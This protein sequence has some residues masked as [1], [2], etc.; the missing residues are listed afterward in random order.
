M[1]IDRDKLRTHSVP[2]DDYLA[3]Q[4]GA[5]AEFRAMWERTAFAR[6]LGVEVIRARTTLNLDQTA[7]AERLGVS[8]AVVEALEDGEEDPGLE[9]LTLLAE[10]A[11]IAFAVTV[12]LTA[13]LDAGTDPPVLHTQLKRSAA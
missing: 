5:D 12:T 3:L 7:F 6:A 13:A 8:L 2:V 10:R 4:R 9:T 11:G 1:T